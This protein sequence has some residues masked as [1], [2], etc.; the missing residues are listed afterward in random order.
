MALVD[1]SL[2]PMNQRDARMA[3]AAQ[4]RGRWIGLAVL[5][6][7]VSIIIVDATVVNVALPTIIRDLGLGTTQAEW[8][9]S[10]YP[11]VFAALLLTLGRLGDVSAGGASS[12]S[13]SSFSRSPVCS[14]RS[15]RAAER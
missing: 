5:S 7:G 6:L 8:I 9:N 14:R 10:V 3:G 12:S 4:D 15:R 13:A 11:L 1:P 2:R